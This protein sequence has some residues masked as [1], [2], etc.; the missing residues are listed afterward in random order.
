[1]N[2]DPR[3]QW[4]PSAAPV[5]PPSKFGRRNIAV[6]PDEVEED[7][8]SSKEERIMNRSIVMAS[9]AFALIAGSAG[10]A[11]IGPVKT[12]SVDRPG[13]RSPQTGGT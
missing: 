6:R 7:P 5:G 8:A 13:E 3:H 10:A 2:G 1:M 4:G 9:V 12:C 11:V